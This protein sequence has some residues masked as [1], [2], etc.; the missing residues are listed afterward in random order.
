MIVWC[1]I[2]AHNRIDLWMAVNSRSSRQ[3]EEKVQMEVI[4]GCDRLLDI[5][6]AS[7]F[8]RVSRSKIYLLMRSGELPYVKLGKCRRVSMMALREL[9]TAHTHGSEEPAESPATPRRRRRSK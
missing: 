8:L 7:A 2:V 4:W 6:E 1:W 5:L 9:V 3:W